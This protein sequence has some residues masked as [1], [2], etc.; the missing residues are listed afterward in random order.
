[1]E[2]EGVLRDTRYHRAVFGFP[3]I[4]SP[5]RRCLAYCRD[6]DH[7]GK[8]G[9]HFSLGHGVARW[10]KWWEMITLRGKDALVAT[11]DG[12]DVICLQPELSVL[13]LL[14][15]KPNSTHCSMSHLRDYWKSTLKVRV[16]KR[17]HTHTQ[18]HTKLVNHAQSWRK[19]IWE[20]FP[21]VVIVVCFKCRMFQL[22]GDLQCEE[23]QQMFQVDLE[24]AN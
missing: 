11:P 15:N 4:T 12:C 6:H 13:L 17:T 19:K 21:L 24:T 16:S 7:S 22:K 8:S 20:T 23:I 5:L 18:R 10:W 1:M 14:A 9:G 2:M 3:M